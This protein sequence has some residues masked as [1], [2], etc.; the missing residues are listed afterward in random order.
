V[1]IMAN[2]THRIT[3]IV[4]VEA[5]QGQQIVTHPLVVFLV[6]IPG[7]IHGSIRIITLASKRANDDYSGGHHSAI[8]FKGQQVVMAHPMKNH[9]IGACTNKYIPDNGNWIYFADQTNVGADDPVLS[10]FKDNELVD[11]GI[12]PFGHQVPD[13]E[14]GKFPKPGFQNAPAFCEDTDKALSTYSFNV[15]LDIGEGTFTFVWLWAFN[16]PQDYYS[17]CF[18]VEIVGTAE[19]RKNKMQ[20]RGQND[21]SLICDSSPISTGAPGSMIGC[22]TQM[23]G[24]D[25][26]TSD[27]T[28]GSD[29]ED[30]DDTHDDHHQND[31]MDDG[32][33]GSVYVNQ[34]TGKIYLPTAV[35]Q[36]SKREIHVIFYA[37][38]ATVARPNF[39]YARLDYKTNDGGDILHRFR[40][41]DGGT[42]SHA[43]HY[44]LQQDDEDDIKRGYVGFHWAFEGSCK[45]LQAPAK[46]HVVDMF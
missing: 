14:V 45:I 33:G 18:D 15:P 25:N 42:Q 31:D 40:R 24:G 35:N 21:F 6:A 7:M 22:D 23:G 16:G 29:D 2:V 30:T 12:S 9:G 11:L 37:D 27:G 17:T 26:D 39:W 41:S 46:V 34:M 44:V 1:L 28:D 3:T 4:N 38:C 5:G 32:T 10:V 19:E 20:A 13:S 36:P 8:Y 43:I